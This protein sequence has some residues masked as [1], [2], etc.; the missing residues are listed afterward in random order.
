MVTPAVGLAMVL[1]LPA[2][3]A[4]SDRTPTEYQ[5]KAA[6]L[7]NFARYV[8]WP[9]D[10]RASAGPFVIAVLGQDPF[11]SALDGTLQ[12]KTLEGRPIVLRRV[13][14]AEDAADSQILFIGDSERERLPAIL[15]HLG[16]DPVLTVGEMSRFA[17]SGGVIGFR[18]EQERVR[19][20]VNLEAAQRSRLRIS[21]ELL[22]LARIVETQRKGE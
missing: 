5:V 11:G 1:L 3:A 7:Y 8:R 19:L 17:E 20:E 14:R 10:P 22:K 16:P 6:F 12:G 9:A 15:A 13:S 18:V 4:A 2:A 21:S